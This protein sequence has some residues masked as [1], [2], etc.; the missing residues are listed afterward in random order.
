MRRSEHQTA[1]IALP[2]AQLRSAMF[3]AAGWASS[4]L[5]VAAVCTSVK[6]AQTLEIREGDTA[7]VRISILDQT[8][9]RAE[10]GRLLDIIGD[11]YDAQRNPAGRIVVLKDEADGEFYLKP[12]PDQAGPMR[13]IKLDIKTDRGTVGLLLQPSE[14]VGDTLTLRVAGGAARQVVSDGSGS[15]SGR[16]RSPAYIRALKAITL[17]M[18]SPG[19]AGELPVRAAEGGAE[20]VALWQEARFVLLSRHDGQGL[21]GETYELTNVSNQRMVIDERELYRAGVRAVSAARL[22]LMPGENTRV[23][24]VRDA[25]DRD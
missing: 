3:W 10:R 23:W 15:S 11:V 14:V 5:L 1:S 7:V 16:A 18:A 22:L 8:R 17:A 4:L 6:A 9:L 25:D 12:V 24:I 19:L 2:R 21:V 13:P 20:V